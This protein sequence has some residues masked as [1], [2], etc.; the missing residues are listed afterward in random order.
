MKQS[1]RNITIALTILAALILP[2]RPGAS[3]GLS[4][5]DLPKAVKFSPGNGLTAYR[6]RDEI[7]MLTITA[8]IGYGSLYENRDNAGIASLLSKTISM[9]GSE[10]YPG[11]A[12][13]RTLEN[14]GG[15]IGFDASWEQTV[16]SITVLDRYA[17]TAFDILS[18]LVAAPRLEE[19]D[20]INARGLIIESLKR[21]RDE[22]H[23][24]AFEKLREIIYDGNGYG[25]MPTEK[26]LGSTTAGDLRT[27]ADRHF[28]S[29]NT[30]LGI[31]SSLEGGRVEGLA[32]KY[33]GS[34]KSGPRTSYGVDTPALVSSLRGKAGKIYFIPRDIPQSTIAVGT[35]APRVTDSEAIPTAVMNYIL[36]GG[37]FN[38]RLMTEIRAKRGLSYSTASV[39]RMRKETGLFLA[40]AQTRNEL[41]PLT[42]SLLE[43]NIRGMGDKLVT[44]GEIDWTRK[45]IANSYIFEFDTPQNILGK[46]LFLD[47]NGLDEAYL[48]T[49]IPRVH[50]VT[51]ENI[52][53][54][55]R[56]LFRDGL[57]RVVV[58]REDVA[59]KLKQLGEVVVLK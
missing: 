22:P 57:V 18:S 52:T 28:T 14:L 29:G 47:Y 15:R 5:I 20:I 12:L 35:L 39:V 24:I 7:P 9:A 27:V 13:Y 3:S 19:A 56:A 49:Y 58:G 44:P 1:I 4:N 36:G 31:T 8:A 33:F 16:I 2:V 37:S 32:R 43:E 17:E 48:K 21:Q 26:T 59:E 38:S 53:A 10:K 41:S 25:A 34:L 30:V 6:I 45:S 54:T 55:G 50:G 11:N 23:F 40:Y 46:Y 42:L 51:P